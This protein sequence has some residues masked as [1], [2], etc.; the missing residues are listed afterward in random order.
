MN[1]SPLEP[2]DENSL[3]VTLLPALSEHEQRIQL[4]CS[5]ISDSQL[6][7]DLLSEIINMCLLPLNLW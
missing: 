7:P 5:Q 3:A 6:F 4:T 1:S 2:P